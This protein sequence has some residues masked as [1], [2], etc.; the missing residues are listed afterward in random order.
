MQ[1]LKNDKTTKEQQFV[2]RSTE[3]LLTHLM[4]E[5][6]IVPEVWALSV[7]IPALITDIFD[8]WVCTRYLASSSIN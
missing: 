6:D 5:D 1:F 2:T 7:F 8:V 4:I 3:K